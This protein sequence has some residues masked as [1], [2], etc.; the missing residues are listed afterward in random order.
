[1][2]TDAGAT[3]KPYRGTSLTRKGTTLGPYRRPMPR[4]LGGS[5]GA[6]RLLC[7]A[8][9]RIRGD[10]RAQVEVGTIGGTGIPYLNR[11]PL[12]LG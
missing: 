9:P 6:E 10:P 3:E 11:N 8:A 5:Q 4:V 7:D 12:Y 1:M 2:Q